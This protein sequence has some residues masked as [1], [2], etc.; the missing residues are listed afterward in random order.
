MK[1]NDDEAGRTFENERNVTQRVRFLEL[2]PHGWTSLIHSLYDQIR[3]QTCSQ[4]VYYMIIF[5]LSYP[6]VNQF[7]GASREAAAVVNA[8]QTDLCFVIA[9]HVYFCVWL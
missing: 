3:W 4:R 7:G 8:L 2:S 5:F 9:L 1:Y 6:N